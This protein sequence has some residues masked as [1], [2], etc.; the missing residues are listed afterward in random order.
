MTNNAEAARTS[1]RAALEELRDTL[2]IQ[3]DSDPTAALAKE[4]RGTLADLAAL[5]EHD[6]KGGEGGETP[7]DE[8]W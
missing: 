3:L 1:R 4:Y 6:P 2:A 8:E 7:A 5:E